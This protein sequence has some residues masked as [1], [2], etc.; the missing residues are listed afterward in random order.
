M[1]ES[2]RKFFKRDTPSIKEEDARLNIEDK[3]VEV[4]YGPKEG[5][6]DTHWREQIGEVSAPNEQPGIAEGKDLGLGRMENASSSTNEK[7]IQNIEERIKSIFEERGG[8]RDP[9]QEA[10]TQK[11]TEKHPSKQGLSNDVKAPEESGTV[12]TPQ[13]EENTPANEEKG[14]F[15]F[16]GGAGGG[17]GGF[18]GGPGRDL[19][20]KDDGTDKFDNRNDINSKIEIEFQ[21]PLENTG[22]PTNEPPRAEVEMPQNEPEPSADRMAAFFQADHREEAERN[23]FP[24]ISD[25]QKEGV[26]M[27][28]NEIEINS[29]E[30]EDGVADFQPAQEQKEALYAAFSEDS[31]R[32][33]EIEDKV[34]DFQPAQEQKEALYAAFSEDGD[35]QP[36]MEDSDAIQPGLNVD[37]DRMAAFL[38]EDSQEVEMVGDVLE[39]SAE[40]RENL[41]QTFS[42]DDEMEDYSPIDESGLEDFALDKNYDPDMDDPDMGDMGD[43]GGS[44]GGSDGGGE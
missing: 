17:G 32:Q 13:V 31:E 30:I 25:G 5:L 10:P 23:E 6:S 44:D 20:I 28:F 27:A 15:G 43:V 24:E 36:E 12:D 11:W 2:I 33:P 42:E 39:I 3:P 21:N 4:E 14:W 1:W 38:K 9:S 29:P 16:G 8:I 34:V 41:F 26:Y 19:N 18:G 37:T 35:R 7:S 22:Q 40:G